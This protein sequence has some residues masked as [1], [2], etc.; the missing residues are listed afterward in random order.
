MRISLQR[1]F[2]VSAFGLLI[3]NGQAQADIF[4]WEFIN[5]SDP[6][7][8][9]QQ[10]ATLCP[11]GAGVSAV[12]NSSLGNRNL[13]M[14]YLAGVSV[15]NIDFSSSNLTNADLNA[16]FLSSVDFTGTNLHQA[17][18]TSAFLQN[19]TL[20]N[21]DLSQADLRNVGLNLADFTGANLSGAMIQGATG[22]ITLT[23][24]LPSARFARDL[25]G[26]K[27]FRWSGFQRSEF[28]RWGN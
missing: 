21:A 26:W 20:V 28:I 3:L 22:G 16:A 18:L 25:F 4:Q 19:A 7:Q 10:S 27:Q 6:S 9:K 8:G 15:S 13:T 11:D 2:I 23:Q 12:D 14:A 24:T 17:D 5:P 1:L